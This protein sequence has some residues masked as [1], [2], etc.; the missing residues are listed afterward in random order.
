MSKYSKPIRNDRS[1]AWIQKYRGEYYAGEFPTTS[2]LL[3]MVCHE[4]PDKVFLE[5]FL[6][7]HIS[8]TYSETLDLVRRISSRIKTL[9]PESDSK[10]VVSGVNS[11][12]WIICYLAV[13]YSGNVVIPL[14]NTLHENEV[15]NLVEFSG[16]KIAFIDDR[17]KSYFNGMNMIDLIGLDKVP[18]GD[19]LQYVVDWA[20]EVVLEKSEDDFRSELF[21]REENDLAAILFTSGTTGNP[22]GVMLTHRN[23]ICDGFYAQQNLIILREDV[24]Y[25]ILPIH[26]AYAMV[27][28]LIV[29][30]EQGCTIV[31]GK[32]MIPKQIF[33]DVK[34]GGVTVFLG[35]P[36]LYNKV[37]KGLMDGIRAKGAFVS[38]F[39][40]FMMGFWAFV[41]AILGFDFS[42]KFFGFVTG[43]VSL[44]NVR[45]LISGGGPLAPIVVKQYNR[46]GMS[47]IEGYGMTETSPISTL[48]PM[49]AYKLGSV[50]RVLPDIEMKIKDADEDGNGLVC[51]KGPIVMKGYYKN[52]EATREIID[53]DG[54]LNTGDIGHLDDDNYLF[55]TG[56][57]KNLIVTSGGKNV[58][59]EE[60]ENEFQLY[61]DVEEIMIAGYTMQDGSEGIMAVV[62]P[63]E[64][65]V[66]QFADDKESCI[67]RIQ[68]SVDEVN[69]TLATYK[70]IS[71]LVVTYDPFPM[72]STRK[73]KRP[74]AL[75]M[76][77][78][79]GLI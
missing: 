36:V 26:H 38:G 54:F 42:K 47:F 8:F 6:P 27:A 1:D 19:S 55:L 44:N 34:E 60:I 63:P 16:A 62:Q 65:L 77:K 46:L 13:Q 76:L 11:P 57:Q 29:P 78:D 59:P 68:K 33:Y 25:A 5:T 7:E 73:I 10:I 58:F 4:C 12:E 39:V 40:K 74:V 66:K 17:K 14:D 72:S 9:I 50:G 69:K 32:K 30:L 52:D 15:R 51:V 48:N 41:K 67:A 3:E 22:K 45:V 64:A 18:T 75:K 49:E 70:K 43:K 61:E 79:K 21:S 35:V 56:R 28:A 24:F 23:L 2:Q 53:E 31:F 37:I 71:K 20:E